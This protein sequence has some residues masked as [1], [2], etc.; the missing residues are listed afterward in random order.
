[1]DRDV[2]RS[3]VI[4]IIEMEMRFGVGTGKTPINMT[5]VILIYI[6][7]WAFNLKRQLQKP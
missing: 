6:S 1:M 2:T 7:V 4:A 3:N 5:Y